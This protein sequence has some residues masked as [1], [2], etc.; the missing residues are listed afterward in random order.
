MT[1]YF[2]HNAPVIPPHTIDMSSSRTC[3]KKKKSR[4]HI[5][6]HALK[7]YLGHRRPRA[8]FPRPAQLH[9]RR[10]LAVDRE[11]DGGPLASQ[12]LVPD[13]ANRKTIE[14]HLKSR[15]L[16]LGVCSSVSYGG[17]GTCT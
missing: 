14:R 12:N 4:E 11:T 1:V 16:S 5:H 8:G 2:V 7:R 3:A 13:A 15:H 6:K 10:D 9:Q 17:K